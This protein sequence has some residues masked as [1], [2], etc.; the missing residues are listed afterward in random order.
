M[1]ASIKIKAYNSW[2]CDSQR[3]STDYFCVRL[4]HRVW[5]IWL[6]LQVKY[7]V[8]FQNKYSESLTSLMLQVVANG[9]LTIFQHSNHC[10]CAG[11]RKGKRIQCVSHTFYSS[12]LN[13]KPQK[14]TTGDPQTQQ[15]W[16]AATSNYSTYIYENY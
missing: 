15:M 4:F 8:C 2:H 6:L 13:E 16:F 1:A 9:V 14:N 10:S 12:W 3:G 5:N 11:T 7:L